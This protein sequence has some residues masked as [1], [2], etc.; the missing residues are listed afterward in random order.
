MIEEVKRGF[1]QHYGYLPEH[2]YFAPG[3]V[4]LIGEHLDYNG[5]H[6][7]PYALKMGV[8]AAAGNPGS[9]KI[10][11]SSAQFGEKSEF[12]PDDEIVKQDQVWHNYPRGVIK[13]YQPHMNHVSGFDMHFDSDLPMGAGISSSAAIEV[14][15]SLALCDL[16]KMDRSL[17]DQ[18]VL[19]RKVENEFVGVGCGIMDQ[20]ISATAIK[21]S[22]LLL[23]CKDLSFRYIPFSFAP[24]QLI[25]AHTGKPRSL[26][27]SAFNDR[28]NKCQVA[29]TEL[30]K[31]YR[32]NELCDLR[33]DETDFSL[34]TDT[35]ACKRAIHVIAENERV[36]KAAGCLA[37]GDL[38]Q[39]AELMNKSHDSLRDYYEVTGFELDTIVEESRKIDGVL[40]A[41]MS[42]AGFGGCSINLVHREKAED[43]KKILKEM[44]EP[45][46]GFKIRFYD[47][48]SGTGACKIQ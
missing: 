22:C 32:I 23:N 24:Y 6:V 21:D 14:V 2:I 17:S 13:Y 36:L 5:G 12:R 44:Y 40:A 35:E 9:D 11:I 7:L 10:R 27:G 38:F 37:N 34:I 15:S 18:A 47:G 46:T 25:I 28:R 4:N 48:I 1:V 43:F 33:F 45:K 29:L 31:H 16:L 41:R 8:Y 26:D 3:R 30:R 20:M 19:C 39:L 42:G